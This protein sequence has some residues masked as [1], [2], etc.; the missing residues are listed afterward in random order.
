MEYNAI[1]KARLKY[2]IN[3]YIQEVLSKK[4]LY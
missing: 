2:N 4:L 1:L 3:T